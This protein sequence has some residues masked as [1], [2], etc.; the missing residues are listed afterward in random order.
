[1]DDVIK[2]IA[3]EIEP[4]L[5]AAINNALC[6]DPE[7]RDRLVMVLWDNK[8]GILRVLQAVVNI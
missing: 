6:D 5:D 1:M 3:A 4:Q 2:R 8:V 7:D